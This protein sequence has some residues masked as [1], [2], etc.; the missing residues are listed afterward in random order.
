MKRFLSRLFRTG[1]RELTGDSPEK[2]IAV[3][4]MSCRFPDAE[5]Y[6]EF[7]KNLKI[8]KSSTCMIPPDRWDFTAYK[9]F[10]TDKSEISKW[11]AFIDGV[12][13]FDYSFFGLSAREVDAMD[14][15]QRIML[16]QTWSCFEDAGIRPTSISGK[17]VGVYLSAFNYDYK[18]LVEQPGND[19]K[20]HHSTGT[21]MTMIPNRISYYF[22]LSGPSILVDNACSGSLTSIHLACQGIRDGDC[23]M[24]LAGG[25]NLLLSPT[26]QISFSKMGML[27]PTGTCKTFDC[28]ADGYVRG[29]G[30]GILL[31]KKLSD[32]ISDGD[33]IHAVIKGSAVNH[34]GRSYTITYPNAKAQASVIEKAVKCAGIPINAISYVEAHGTG[35]PKGDPIEF[36]GLL[37]AFKSDDMF[38]I[39][40]PFCGIGSAKTN[41]GHLEAAAGVAGV[42]KVIMSMKNRMLPPLANFTELNPAIQTDA[43]PFYMIDKLQAWMPDATNGDGLLKAGISSFGFGGTNG[44]IIMQEYKAHNTKQ[45][46]TKISHIICLSAKNNQSLLRRVRDLLHWLET[47]EERPD[48]HDVAGTLLMGREHFK[49]RTSFVSDSIENLK[50][51]LRNFTIK[52]IP[53]NSMHDDKK[54]NLAPE[55][56]V[57]IRNICCQNDKS[58]SAYKKQLEELSRLYQYRANIEWDQVFQCYKKRIHIPTYPFSKEECWIPSITKTRQPERNNNSVQELSLEALNRSTQD[59]FMGLYCEEWTDSFQEQKHS[60]D[61]GKNV[62]VY[63]SKS[64]SKNVISQMLR[65]EYPGLQCSFIDSENN[66]DNYYGASVAEITASLDEIRK[67]KGK[68]DHVFYLPSAEDSEHLIDSESLIRLLKGVNEAGVMEA[69]I[70]IMGY[71]TNQ[72]ERCYLDS[73]IGFERSRQLTGLRNRLFVAGSDSS[74]SREAALKVIMMEAMV[75]DTVSFLYE[76]GKK[77]VCTV[78]E[79]PLGKKNNVKIRDGGVYVI[80][81]GLGGLGYIF[82]EWLLKKY[83]ANLI[84]ISKSDTNQYKIKALDLLTSSGGSVTNVKA[85]VTKYDEMKAIIENIKKKY[86]TIHGFIQAAGVEGNGS[87]LHNQI[88]DFNNIVQTKIN[89][90]LVVNALLK[91]DALDFLCY[92]S[93]SSA[94]IGDLG[95][96]AYSVG[97]RFLLALGRSKGLLPAHTQVICWPLWNSQG[98]G[99]KDKAQRDMYLKSSGQELVEAHDG[100]HLFER[101]ISY[102]DGPYLVFK[103]NRGRIEQ[104]LHLHNR[105]K[106]AFVGAEVVSTSISYSEGEYEM[107][108]LD[109]I[110]KEAGVILSVSVEAIDINENLVNF[111]F[112]SVTLTVFSDY[113]YGKYQVKITPDIFY[114]YPTLE[115]LCNYMKDF[116]C[117]EIARYYSGMSV[118]PVLSEEKEDDKEV[119][120][121]VAK[122]DDVCC[123]VSVVGMSLRVPG[124]DTKEEFWKLLEQ[125]QISYGHLPEARKMNWKKYGGNKVNVETAVVGMVTDI[126][127]F[128]PLF[129][130]IPPIE[131]E[132][133]DPRQRLLL[134]EIYHALEDAGYNEKNIA[135]ERIGIFIG[136]EDGDYRLIIPNSENITANHNGILA[137]RLAYYLDL[138][139]PVITTNTACSSGLVA[140]HQA[141]VSIERGE[142]DTAVVAAANLF[143]TDDLY[144]GMSKMG[145][146]SLGGQSRAFDKNADGM[147]PSEA[148]AVLIIK[149][150][151]RAVMDCNPL[152]GQVI[153][154]GVNYDGK[155]G[156]ITAPS[157]KAQAELIKSIYEKYAI[158]PESVSYIITHGSSTKIGDPVEVNAL[159]DAF[160]TLGVHRLQYCPI[161]SNKSNIGHTLAASGLVNIINLLL[162]FK[163]QTKPASV[164]IS[165]LN[166][167]IEWDNSPFYI[168]RADEAWAGDA[169]HWIGAVNSFGMSG[170]NAHVVLRGVT[171]PVKDTGAVF[172]M[173]LM[174]LS[175]KTA[176]SLKK[177]AKQL[178]QL[179]CEN[180]GLENKDFTYIC[181]T[182]LNNRIHYSYRCAFYFQN[183][184]EAMDRLRQTVTSNEED[185]L[186]FGKIPPNSIIDSESQEELIR[187]SNKIKD[188][189]DCGVEIKEH[190]RQ[191]AMLYCKGYNLREGGLY[192]PCPVSAREIIMPKYPFQNSSYWYDSNITMSE[193]RKA[194]LHPLV[195]EN[196]SNI[197]EQ[198]YRSV[199]DGSELVFREHIINHVQL[200]P[201]VAYLE[202]A[203]RVVLNST[204]GIFRFSGVVLKDVAWLKPLAYQGEDLTINIA[205]EA[206]NE[207]TIE[208]E[209]FRNLD[210][211]EFETYC[212]GLAEL[213]IDTAKETLN[214]NCIKNQGALIQSGDDFYRRIKNRGYHYGAGFRTIENIY[215]SGSD[216]YGELVLPV[217]ISETLNEYTIHPTML[218]GAFQLGILFADGNGEDSCE[219]PYVPFAVSEVEVHS[220]CQLKMWAKATK[221]IMNHQII[222]YNVTLFDESGQLCIQVT[223]ITMKVL[224]PMK[225]HSESKLFTT[226]EK[227]IN[228]DRVPSIASEKIYCIL[229]EKL[230]KNRLLEELR[231]MGMQVYEIKQ[232][233][234]ITEENIR[235]IYKQI[236]SCTKTLF[237]QKIKEN[238]LLQVVYNQQE[239]LNLLSGGIGF[240]RT[241]K[242]ENPRI[243]V[244][245]VE[246]RGKRITSTLIRQIQ[247]LSEDKIM[248]SQGEVRAETEAILYDSADDKEM[249][250]ESGGVYLVTGGMGGL[251]LIFTKEI[252]KHTDK[253]NIILVGRSALEPSQQCILDELNSLSGNVYYK[254][255]NISKSA[256]VSELIIKITAEYGNLSGIIH[257]AGITRDNFV[258]KKSVEEFNEVISPKIDGIINLDKYTKDMQLK[259]FIGF[260]SITGYYGNA[261]QS[262]YALG[263]GF[264]DVYLKYRQ[265][266]VAKGRRKGRTISI[267]WPLWK[268]GGMQVS[269]AIEKEMEANN[270]WCPMSTQ[271]GIHNFYKIWN[272]VE[273]RVICLEMLQEK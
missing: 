231:Q 137:A 163:Y 191:L 170:T 40:K 117:D 145:M 25:I 169:D 7:W 42:I 89:G 52:D 111:G 73:L 79:L 166:D 78:K 252:L 132:Q 5:N 189:A 22:N 210:N 152:Y 14:P 202:A 256:E 224:E 265:Y 82:S 23:S 160:K 18:E 162:S 123:G 194:I 217:S 199:F 106:D 151:S 126:D 21:S 113:L 101:L 258:V 196:V 34:G 116:Y 124:A 64:S 92:F 271:A 264:M 24:A 26:R 58:G 187:L 4:G 29:E 209:I 154:T 27:S 246:L 242:K 235:E 80:T 47:K 110:K 143:I 230:C 257:A 8:S 176:D 200:L 68:I 269:K 119:I 120:E 55:V 94:I 70:V 227:V 180:P 223:G 241:L 43:T 74:L 185:G 108:F 48:L 49:C 134:E 67:I 207:S 216:I 167:Y 220:R 72:L 129:F 41:I 203:Y 174:V 39:K 88:K 114:S 16:E 266:M 148:I 157:R 186:Y 215:R 171:Q 99:F 77:K 270:G 236:Y 44:H 140:F 20:A 251:G 2:D 83:H 128:D 85:D 147:L 53:L 130:E 107:S 244:Q 250:W 125:H 249:P 159:Q 146:I 45:S 155:T 69:K 222:K 71:Y 173:H 86:G 211:G 98:M 10:E 139:G 19:I 81:G 9:A 3:V 192:E 190:L 13:Y 259:F 239:N 60:E 183:Q 17:D 201:A 84:L 65:Q 218:D 6:E 95:E 32:A 122:Q 12:K 54:N 38:D 197:M 255:C 59:I 31:L 268:E 46:N 112:D 1:K 97:N 237:H 50:L 181:A 144:A 193:V 57:V 175:A 184:Q 136:A 195:H 138:S 267:N 93:S 91:Q 158:N 104:F 56:E 37:K 63:I 245:L 179:L 115:A 232:P 103:G 168:N 219:L 102:N 96:C 11:G 149:S 87:V 30:A 263:N 221:T 262:D 206:Q 161:F 214:I 28:N 247:A 253:C 248:I 233:D 178:L 229:D 51:Q 131:A 15:Q 135:N 234:I 62:V 254:K 213:G 212:Q 260:S 121:S 150:T 61:T 133:M 33:D 240:L 225:G 105:K 165:E 141:C 243:R 208:F 238:I 172:A 272:T 156:G 273:A 198:C 153:G 182:L 177:K 127:Q 205:L 188:N 164:G 142:C 76:E 228:I 118:E 100:V 109:D 261:G 75:N 66:K 204:A 226:A 90:A 36:K 35:T